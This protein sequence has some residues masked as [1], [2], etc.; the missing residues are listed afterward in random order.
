MQIVQAAKKYAG[1]ILLAGIV[2]LAALMLTGCGA[3][4]TVYDYTN[5][6][7]RYNVYE[8]AIDNDVVEQMEKTA[9]ENKDGEKYTVTSYF[10]ELFT[11]F[12]YKLVGAAQTETQRILRYSR[13]IKSESELYKEGTA[14]E[15][16]TTY[17]ENPFTREY[18][19][20]SPNP[21]NG[22]REAYDNARAGQSSTVIERLKNGIVARNEYHEWVTLFPSVTDAFPYLKDKNPDGLLLNYA[23]NGSARMDS[24]G[25]ATE[26]DGDNSKYVFSRY[27]D[28]AESTIEFDYMRPVTYGWYMVA[29]AAGGITLAVFVIATRTKKQKPTLL[30]RFPYNP[31]EY[32]DYESHLPWAK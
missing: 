19:A 27:F 13:E 15:F 29:L 32:R 7:V 10:H 28:Y 14:V 12:G 5:D 1:K 22:V 26:I 21:F 31:E 20:A 9:A 25:V 3:S 18:T 4:L 17:T 16:T 11:G 6:G 23:R 30:D 2:C 8:L 24:S